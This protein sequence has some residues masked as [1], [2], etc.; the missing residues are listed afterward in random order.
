MYSK[1]LLVWCS[2]LLQAGK[3]ALLRCLFSSMASIQ[4]RVRG[5][6]DYAQHAGPRNSDLCCIAMALDAELYRPGSDSRHCL[7]T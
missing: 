5:A 6:A 3:N 1:G 2:L 4:R 7:G